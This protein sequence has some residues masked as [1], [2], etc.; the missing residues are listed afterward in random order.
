MLYTTDTLA[1]MYF[2]TQHTLGFIDIETS[3]LCKSS[4]SI[5]FVGLA[6]YE[7]QSLTHHKWCLQAK[8]DEKQIIAACLDMLKK[9]TLLYSYNG[10][11][12]DLNF[13][14]KKALSYGFDPLLS[15]ELKH[16]D[17]KKLP[18]FKNMCSNTSLNR[19]ILESQLG[20]QRVA[21]A[22]GRGLAK[23]NLCYLN[24]GEAIYRQIMVAH[25]EEDLKSLL[26]MYTF[27]SFMKQLSHASLDE[28]RLDPSHLILRFKL[29]YTYPFDLSFYMG[30]YKL[31]YAASSHFLEVH[32]S[33]SV[34]TLKRWLPY[35]DYFVVSGELLHHSLVTFIP[36]AYKKKA[37]K[38]EAFIQ[39]ENLFIYHPDGSW[40]DDS[41]R[42]YHLYTPDLPLTPY[43]YDFAKKITSSI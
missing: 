38:E 23:N 10:T 11:A 22:H 33:P 1:P 17:F 24:T 15:S 19:D 2:E 43:S 28:W 6:I 42:C 5:L 34:L 39:Q 13:I 37:T 9:V 32:L 14:Q 36:S 7:N 41:G 21:S 3:G 16:I 20:H 12:F 8:D 31:R 18:L 30:P 35:K 4:A 29:K 25:H 26:T 27:Y 40:Q